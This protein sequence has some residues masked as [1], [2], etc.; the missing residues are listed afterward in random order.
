MHTAL[1]L[2]QAPAPETPPPPPPKRAAITGL[3]AFPPR[4]RVDKRRAEKLPL[5]AHSTRRWE[6]RREQKKKTG[7]RTAFRGTPEGD[8]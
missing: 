6:T 2:S 5:R 1:D 4:G 7:G 8:S 3:T